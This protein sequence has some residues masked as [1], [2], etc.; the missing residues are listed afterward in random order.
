M[1]IKGVFAGE[2]VSN[3]DL[4][5][6]LNKIVKRCIFCNLKLFYIFFLKSV[7]NFVWENAFTEQSKVFLDLEAY[8]DTFDKLKRN[9]GKCLKFFH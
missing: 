1:Y 2:L 4:M 8:Q 5:E 3:A 9:L 7:P 6:Y